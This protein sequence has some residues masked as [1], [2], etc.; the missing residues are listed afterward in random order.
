MFL[1]TIP[2]IWLCPSK[3]AVPVFTFIPVAMSQI[4]SQT[5]L[6]TLYLT[7][8]FYV[9]SFSRRFY[10]KIKGL[11]RLYL[12]YN[13]PSILMNLL[14]DC[15]CAALIGPDEL[16]IIPGVF[17]PCQTLRLSFTFW[18]YLP[19]MS[20]SHNLLCVLLRMPYLSEAHSLGI[21]SL[22]GILGY[23]PRYLNSRTDP[24]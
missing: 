13:T 6:D 4:V 24:F 19:E 2:T 11:W 10:P 3:Y 12:W 17:S 14:S 1:Y 23:T 18:W 7:F 9:Y 8:T 15:F 21:P 5:S 20:S 22:G 16:C